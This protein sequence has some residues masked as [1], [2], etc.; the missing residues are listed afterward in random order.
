MSTVNQTLKTTSIHKENLSELIQDCPL[1]KTSTDQIGESARAFNSLLHTLFNQFANQ[2][3]IR[4]FA[5]LLN[6][7][8]K[9]Q[10]TADEALSLLMEDIDAKGGA[11]AIEQ[12]GKLKINTSKHMSCFFT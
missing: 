1:C 7:K 11:L 6:S 9:M 8:L 5:N 4:N 12:K 10:E 2:N 3:K